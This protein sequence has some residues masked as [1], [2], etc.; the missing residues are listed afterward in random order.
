MNMNKYIK[1]NFSLVKG[2]LVG[3]LCCAMVVPVGLFLTSILPIALILVIV[4]I[5]LF[6]RILSKM[7]KTMFGEGAVL[8]QSLPFSAKEVVVTKTLVLTAVTSIAWAGIMGGLAMG[9]AVINASTS[10]PGLSVLFMEL[11]EEV[12]V[13]SVLVII[14][15]LI[16]NGFFV[17]ATLLATSITTRLTDSYMAKFCIFA[18]FL[19]V[20]SFQRTKLPELLMLL[21]GQNILA[22]SVLEILATLIMGLCASLI[23]KYCLEK[24]YI[25]S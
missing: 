25:L 14:C 8:Y 15:T 11:M 7:D 1:M 6:I 13:M 9:L 22:A 20:F 17:A 12:G 5:V 19:L 16:A 21:M 3:L 10:E 2:E 18:V 4:M 24:K 23:S